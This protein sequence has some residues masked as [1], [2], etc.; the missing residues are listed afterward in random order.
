M[1]LTFIFEIQKL[2]ECEVVSY[3]CYVKQNV[4]APPTGEVKI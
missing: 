4:G 3:G 1:Q 2:N